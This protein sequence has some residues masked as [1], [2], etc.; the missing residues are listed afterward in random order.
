MSIVAPPTTTNLG[1]PMPSEKTGG[2]ATRRGQFAVTSRLA[3]QL[4]ITPSCVVRP[5]RRTRSGM[6]VVR[7][8]RRTS[9][10]TVSCRARR[11]VASGCTP[12]QSV[13]GAW[14]ALNSSA[15]FSVTVAGSAHSRRAARLRPCRRRGGHSLPLVTRGARPPTGPRLSRLAVLGWA[16]EWDGPRAGALG[17]CLWLTRRRCH[18]ESSATLTVRSVLA[19]A[20]GRCLTSEARRDRTG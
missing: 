4:G 16:P 17:P 9:S 1:S 19:T 8:Y 11:G 14:V 13:F 7:S 18:R 20:S 15:S 12:V 2:P 5:R 10:L 6:R 3:R